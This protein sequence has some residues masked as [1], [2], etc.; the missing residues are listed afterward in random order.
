THDGAPVQ[1]LAEDG[2]GRHL[3][4]Q[5]TG[6]PGRVRQP[7]RLDAQD[8]P[9]FTHIAW[10]ALGDELADWLAGSYARVAALSA[11]AR[12]RL[13]AHV[14]H[15]GRQAGFTLK[16]EFAYLGHMMT[17]LGGW[18]MLAGQFPDLEA[19]LRQG[20]HARHKPLRPAFAEAWAVSPLRLGAGVSELA[21]AV[22]ALPD[23]PFIPEETA[24]DLLAR[25]IPQGG[26]A[27]A[28][29]LAA[30]RAQTAMFGPED[31]GANLVL[32]VG[33]GYRFH[34]DPMREWA[35]LPWRQAA[36]AAC[37]LLQKETG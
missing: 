36:S 5:P 10:A 30:I 20:T 22:A 8:E 3:S 9:I 13:A 27:M 2:P 12:A 14:L 28:R 15:I 35:G 6:Q 1:W 18:F 16:D 33:L 31:R 11:Q 26:A 24:H 19:I 37:D 34:D 29:F 23:A 32:S 17:H 25:H 21:R 7:I 4:F